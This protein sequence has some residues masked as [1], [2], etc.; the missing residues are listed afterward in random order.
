[1]RTVDSPPPREFLK[2]NH[3]Y[4]APYDHID[5]IPPIPFFTAEEEDYL[6]EQYAI[7]G[8]RNSKS[9]TSRFTRSRTDLLVYSVT[10]LYSRQ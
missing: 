9:L 3:S 5:P 6:V 10:V 8:F 1:M 4:L 2:S 7:Q